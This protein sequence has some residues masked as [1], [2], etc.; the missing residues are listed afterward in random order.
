MIDRNYVCSFEKCGK[1]YASDGSLQQHIRLKHE[2]EEIKGEG[3]LQHRRRNSKLE[4][5]SASESESESEY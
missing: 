4:V 3:P 2:Q 1:V 5:Y